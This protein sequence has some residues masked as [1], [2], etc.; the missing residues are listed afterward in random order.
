[1]ILALGV[2][3]V[4]VTRSPLL[5]VDRIAV[6]GAS[7]ASPDAV[8][9]ATGIRRHSPMT[10]LDLG[11]ARDGVLLLPWVKSAA[12]TRQWPGTVKAGSVCDVPV[13]S[14]D[15]YPTILEM[16]G[17]KPEPKQIEGGMP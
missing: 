5:D 1:M 6:T 3:S 11:R 14:V 10:D 13:S 17:G 8:R 16:S 15:F 12:V 9:A 2:A 4:L 7:H